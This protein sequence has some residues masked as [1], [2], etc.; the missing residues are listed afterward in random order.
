[1]GDSRGHWQGDTLVVET[2]NFTSH[3]N[4]NGSDDKM[5][6]TERFTRTG[7][8]SLRYQFTIDDPSAFTAPWTVEVPMNR[9]PLPIYE[10]ACHE[11]NYGM[12]GILSG[13]RAVEKDEKAA[14]DAA[15]KG[16]N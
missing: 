15:K 10:Y 7:D 6:L 1:M 16:S 11:G 14:A 8:N 4:F 2:T 12:F 9:N 5:R 3:T 13:A